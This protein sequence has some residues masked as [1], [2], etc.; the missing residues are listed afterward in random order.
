[1]KNLFFSVCKY[2]HLV[3]TFA[4]FKCENYQD[5]LEIAYKSVFDGSAKLR[6]FNISES[7]I[8]SDRTLQSD[9]LNKAILNEFIKNIKTNEKTKHR[10]KFFTTYRM[11]YALIDRS[12]FI[13]IKALGKENMIEGMKTARF[14]NTIQGRTFSVSKQMTKELQGLNLTTIPPVMFV[15][16]K[17]EGDIINLINLQYYNGGEVALEYKM[18]MQNE[19]INLEDKFKSRNNNIQNDDDSLLSVI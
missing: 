14:E 3:G 7:F 13:C 18:I 4:N 17:R 9:F 8:F 6:R 12:F 5:I 19:S 10:V 1:M 15:G 2:T 16:F 11:T